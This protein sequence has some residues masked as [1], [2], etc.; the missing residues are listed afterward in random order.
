MTE[1]VSRTLRIGVLADYAE[2]QWPSMDLTAR[3]ITQHLPAQLPAGS[4]VECHR[5]TFHRRASA[6]L[7]GRRLG[8]A[9]WSFDRLANRFFDYPRECASLRAKFDVFHLVDHSYAQLLH[10]L[11]PERVVVTCHDLD[12]FRCLIQPK[13]FPHG[14]VFRA[15]T[16]RILRGLQ[17]AAH[18]FC[19]SRAT[20][21][22]IVAHDLLPPERLSICYLGVHSACFE[23]VD[24]REEPTRREDAAITILHVGSTIPRKRIDVLLE[25]FAAVRREFPAARLLRAG[26]PFTA[27][28]E[29]QV[30]RLG[31]GDA[32]VSLGL[33]PIESVAAEYRRATLVFQPS[34]AEGF[35]LPVAEAMASGTPVLASDL[36][37]LREVGGEAASYAPVGDVPR[38]TEQACALLHERSMAPAQWQARRERCRQQA[39]KF[40]WAENARQAAEI[41]Q[42]LLA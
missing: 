9:A 34:D 17:K 38:W 10:V 22:E 12:T 11:A 16:R 28:Q 32:I 3:M 13:L 25:G 19:D 31:I 20:R 30:A 33:L 6:L 14:A 39:E 1:S 26:G 4:L 2:E 37:V 41:Y 42:R 23:P 24:A 29:A 5:P 7:P 8:R 15:M 35:G 40:S 18:V 36:P 21:D 27:A